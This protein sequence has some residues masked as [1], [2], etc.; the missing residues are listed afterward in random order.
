MTTLADWTHA[1]RAWVDDFVLTLRKAGA[2]RQQIGLHLESVHDRCEETGR[3][4]QEECGEPADCARSMGFEPQASD[5]RGIV[6]TAFPVVIQVLLLL[7]GSY[8]IRDWIT[9]SALDINWGTLLCWIALV[10]IIGVVTATAAWGS[11][12]MY[13]VW[14]FGIVF[15][16]AVVLGAAGAVLSRTGLPVIFSGTPVFIAAT[17]IIGVF[18]IAVLSTVRTLR[19][20]RVRP[21]GDDATATGSTGGRP[22]AA[23]VLTVW[24]VPVYMAFDTGFTAMTN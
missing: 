22:S 11:T 10:A 2:T 15:G 1:H 4:P 16:V 7:V 3:A 8:A 9:G 17:A 20:P 23:L 12:A 19:A 5:G 18:A 6:R 21:Q 24:M 14:V 13:N